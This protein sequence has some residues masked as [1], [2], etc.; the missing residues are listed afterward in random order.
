MEFEKRVISND[1]W[2][3]LMYKEEPLDELAVDE[4][5]ALRAEFKGGGCVTDSKLPNGSVSIFIV[6]SDK[7]QNTILGAFDPNMAQSLADGRTLYVEW[8]ECDV[9]ARYCAVPDWI[10]RTVAVENDTVTLHTGESFNLLDK[11]WGTVAPR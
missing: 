1:A 2:H 11:K 5:E 7:V 3:L 10:L 9:E 6:P 8:L 4:V